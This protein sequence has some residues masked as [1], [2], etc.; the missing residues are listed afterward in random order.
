MSQC[1]CAFVPEG[2]HRILIEGD[3]WHEK[4]PVSVCIKLENSRLFRALGE[5]WLSWLLR[6]CH[7][8][9]SPRTDL[10]AAF[11]E[12]TGQSFRCQMH[13]DAHLLSVFVALQILH[14][15]IYAIHR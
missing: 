11:K 14:G 2:V 10:S 1:T 15:K 7:T 6:L 8:L 4:D 13:A 5:C 9:L 3:L 12:L